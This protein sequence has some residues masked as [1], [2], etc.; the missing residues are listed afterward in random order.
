MLV[1]QHGK[2]VNVAPNMHGHDKKGNPN[3]A[4][5][6]V[7]APLFEFKEPGVPKCGEMFKLGK[8]ARLAK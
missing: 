8:R 6:A 3:W 7:L 5:I 1:N 4:A 2:I